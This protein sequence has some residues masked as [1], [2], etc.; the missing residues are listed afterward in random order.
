MSEQHPGIGYGAVS[1]INHW[2]SA[3]IVIALLVSGMML[4]ELPRGPERL[5]LINFHNGV[6]VLT[7]LFILF[8]VAW[9]LKQGFAAEPPGPR[10]QATAARAAHWMLLA[11]MVVLTV[12][13]PFWE[14]AEGHDLNVFGWF[15][16][17]TPMAENEA[18]ENVTH[19]AHALTAKAVLMPVL[20]LHVL[21]ALKRAIF[22]RDGTLQ[23]MSLK[24]S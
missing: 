3:I 1:V 4:E 23:R 11:A 15:T 20:I 13:G 17:A 19:V 2:L 7:A 8:R 6:G 16:L 18:L 5:A 14:W 9:R 22:D 12:T 24:Q 21:A 10:W